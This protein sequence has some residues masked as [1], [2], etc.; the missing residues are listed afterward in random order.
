MAWPDCSNH[1]D[2]VAQ[3]DEAIRNYKTAQNKINANE[4]DKLGGRDDQ[5]STEAQGAALTSYNAAMTWLNANSDP[6]C[7]R[8]QNQMSSAGGPSGP[9]GGASDT[10]Q[11]NGKPTGG[12]SELSKHGKSE[13]ANIPIDDKTHK[14]P[15]IEPIDQNADPATLRDEAI[16]SGNYTD[17]NRSGTAFTNNNQP[18]E[19]V[20]D[21][22]RVLKQD[23][24]NLAARLGRAKARLMLG[25]KDGAS[26]D[27]KAVLAQ[28]PKNQIAAL[29]AGHSDSL[30]QAGSKIKFGA[31]FGA[32]RKTADSAGAPGAGSFGAAAAGALRSGPSSAPG[33][34]AQPGTRT[35]PAATTGGPAPG[36]ASTAS[37]YMQAEERF[38]M[39][40]FTGA[41]FA[42]RQAVDQEPRDAMAWSLLAKINNQMGNYK[43][44][45]QAAAQALTLDP[46]NAQALRA[47][48]YAEIQLGNYADAYRDALR[49][50]Q[51]D[52]KNGLGFM[53]LAMA[54]EKLGKTDDALKHYEQAISLDTTLA[55]V[56]QDALKRLRGSSP[57]GLTNT[58]ERHLARGGYIAI[59]LILVLLGLLGTAA[60]RQITT[61]AKRIIGGGTGEAQALSE[62][63]SVRPGMLLGGTF[64]VRGELGRGGMGVVYDAMDEALERRVAIKQLQRVEGVTTDDLERLLKEARLVAKLSHPHIAQIFTVLTEGDLFL[65]FEYIDGQ[66]LHQI[67]SRNRTLP[68]AQVRQVLSEVAAALDYA[69]SQKIIHRDLKPSNIMITKDGAA[70]VMDF[71]IAHQSRGTAEATMTV[72]SGTPQY[73]APEQAL[74]SVSKASDVYALGVM[75]YEMLT[76]ARPFEGPDFL[77]Q[78]LRKE[79]V[80]PSK[81]DPRLPPGFDAFFASVFEPDPTKRPPDANSFIRGFDEACS[82]LRA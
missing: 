33:A 71:G 50:T 66:P 6:D 7:T 52:A 78:K 54:E 46:E 45:L 43:G 48:A 31:N 79:F 81:R 25:D 56:A 82:A 75:A 30:S 15:N 2:C 12:A 36:T 47:K 11:A 41:F 49:S 68:A 65:V 18:Q 28:D 77:E 26:S 40:D 21:F 9:K 39:N 58:A 19:A 80:P 42:A 61:K 37:L 70:K 8:L 14:D 57:I 29:I 22:N 55:A 74:G 67:L 64:R 5:P 17:F 34:A 32:A 35:A 63:P 44:A 76:G 16:N 62:A 53:Y 13:Y 59:S 23:P 3:A 51:L 69:H 60:G 27:A 10:P 4:R 73:M 20:D 1:N 72:A 24:Q 38:R